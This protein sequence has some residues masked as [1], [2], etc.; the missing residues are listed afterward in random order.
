LQRVVRP[1]GHTCIFNGVG[2]RF[3]NQPWGIFGGQPGASGSF[4]LESD[5]EATRQLAHKPPDMELHPHQA[6]VVNT[7]GAGGYGAPAD[8]DPAAL[9][10][11][12]ASGKFSDDYMAT[13][14]GRTD[15]S[16]D[17]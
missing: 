15:A 14:Y 2:E 1:L 10:E 13:H 3:R 12:R 9:A 16:A 5:R 11:D 7:P 8:R 6:L 17:D 4:W